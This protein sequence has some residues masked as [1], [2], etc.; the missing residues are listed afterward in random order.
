M[1]CWLSELS[2][3]LSV[4]VCEHIIIVAWTYYYCGVNVVTA[5]WKQ[6]CEHYFSSQWVFCKPTCILPFIGMTLHEDLLKC[7]PVVGER[8][9]YRNSSVNKIIHFW[10]TLSPLFEEFNCGCFFHCMYHTFE[11]LYMCKTCLKL[12]YTSKTSPRLMH[13]FHFYFH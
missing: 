11:W 8:H 4:G 1:V 6:L 5:L 10:L 2:V 12:T 13:A 3:S 9:L 7:I